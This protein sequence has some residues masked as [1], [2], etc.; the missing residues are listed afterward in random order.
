MK[1]YNDLYFMALESLN[2]DEASIAYA[3]GELD[4]PTKDLNRV[5]FLSWGFPPAILPLRCDSSLLIYEGYWKHWFCDRDLSI[6]ELWP[7]LAKES[8]M[9]FEQWACLIIMKDIFA[10][11]DVTPEIRAFASKVGID[12]LSEI[13]DLT[14]NGEEDSK[15]LASLSAFKGNLPLEICDCSVDYSGSFPNQGMILSEENLRNVCGFEVGKGLFAKIQGLDF[16]PDWLLVTERQDLVFEKAYAD[17]DYLACWMSLNSPGWQA[18]KAINAMERLA[19]R[20][21]D[22]AFQCIAEAWVSSFDG[23]IEGY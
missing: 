5:P 3:K 11:D 15:L 23:S 10:K 8:A 20:Q 1:N 9:N 18:S 4:H 21:S 2:V 16:S 7:N 19:K 6:V 14:L 22:N 12:Y 17:E 13:D